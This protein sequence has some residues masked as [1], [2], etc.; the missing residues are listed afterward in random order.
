[1]H[2]DEQ[3]MMSAAL[4]PRASVAMLSLQLRSAVQ[5]AA[6]TE[7]SV[8]AIDQEAA[9]EELRSRLAPLLADRRAQ[10]ESSLTA[11]REAAAAEVSAARRV[12][13]VMVATAKSPAVRRAEP[14]PQWEPVPLAP[15]VPLVPLAPLVEQAFTAA[16]ESPPEPQFVHEP[17]PALV[18][19]DVAAEPP[20][21]A[22]VAAVPVNIGIDAEAFA[23]VFA[24]VF[25]SMLDERL[26]GS[27]P[28]PGHQFAAIPVAPQLPKKG[29]WAS[30][31]HVDVLLLGAAM[32]IM[33]VVLAAWL[34]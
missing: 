2:S 19:M 17:E 15:L 6:A 28:F 11:A 31:L 24:A 18:V 27:P 25:A 30:A 23:R 33:L 10:L 32:V 3:Q 7:A 12:A 20:R 9:R 13:E 4:S 34:A 14:D 1:M 21:V 16:P 26:A 5:A 29:F 8:A 22:P